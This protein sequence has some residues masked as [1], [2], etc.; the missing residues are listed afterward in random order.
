MIAVQVREENGVNG[1]RGNTPPLH[2]DEGRG[3]T[4]KDEVIMIGSSYV[5]ACLVPATAAEGI[6]A[7][8][9]LNSNIWH[10]YFTMQP[11][12]LPLRGANAVSIPCR[13]QLRLSKKA[14]FAEACCPLSLYFHIADS[15]RSRTTPPGFWAFSLAVFFLSL[16]S[17]LHCPSTPP[18]SPHS[19]VEGFSILWTMH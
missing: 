15:C 9:K 2:G 3:P 7:T 13:G 10:V 18:V 11:N 4:I 14:F 12:A 6:S 1:G 19:I 16:L 17:E 5:D 8:K